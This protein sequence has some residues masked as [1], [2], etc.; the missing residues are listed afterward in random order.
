MPPPYRRNQRRFGS[1]R[2]SIAS[3]AS[4]GHPRCNLKLVR[5]FRI[6]LPLALPVFGRFFLLPRPRGHK[7]TAPALG[8]HKTE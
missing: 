6:S 1:Q 4:S 7:P 5:L 2:V 3:Q 8:Q